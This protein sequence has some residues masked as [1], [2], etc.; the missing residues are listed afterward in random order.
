V[1]D[2]RIVTTWSRELA[3]FPSAET[4]VYYLEEYLRLYEYQ[5][6]SAECFVYEEA[7]GASFIF[8]YLRA[9]EGHSEETHDATTA[10]GYGGPIACPSD[11]AFCARGWEAMLDSLG[12]SG[13]RTAFI[14]FH[15]LLANH[16]VAPEWV[17]ARFV[18]EVV[19]IDLTPSIDDIWTKQLDSNSRNMVRKAETNNLD[20]VVDH[21]FEYLDEFVDMYRE[22]MT[23]LD[24]DAVYLFD[25]AYFRRFP[26][27]L[28]D[29]SALCVV[30]KDHSVVAG[31]LFLCNGP[32]AHYHLSGSRR[33]ALSLRPN[34]LLVYRAALAF[35]DRGE[36]LL[37]LG[38]GRTSAP[39]DGLFAFKRRFAN[40]SY[41][42]YT[43]EISFPSFPTRR[44]QSRVP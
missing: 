29:V 30:T 10:Y 16:V 22:T 26:E 38:G 43:A 7:D 32:Y 21:D 8:P 18:R 37:L 3:R 36:R 31:A 14:R 9:L 4:D 11:E 23:S 19:A 5:G 12:A 2:S 33:N 6:F 25:D 40:L 34:D 42:F 39:D 24:A 17:D 1:G 35:R 27:T 15:P 13:M 20:F 44:E 41:G 28:R